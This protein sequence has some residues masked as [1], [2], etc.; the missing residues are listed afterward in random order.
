MQSSQVASMVSCSS[1]LSIRMV[2]HFHHRTSP[3]VE[4][5]QG[6]GRTCFLICYYHHG[7]SLAL[8][9]ALIIQN[10]TE[11]QRTFFPKP[12]RCSLFALIYYEVIQV[13]DMM[14]MCSVGTSGI[15]GYHHLKARYRRER[16]TCCSSGTI[17][18]HDVPENLRRYL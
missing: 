5:A 3:N 18:I 6:W 13:R 2:S 17:M 9:I 14:Y 7:C 12:A 4:P 11:D 16:V 8:H 15:V 1:S 10:C